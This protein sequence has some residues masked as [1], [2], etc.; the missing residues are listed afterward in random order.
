MYPDCITDLQ[1][2]RNRDRHSR[3]GQGEIHI[4]GIERQGLSELHL[5]A[6][7]YYCQG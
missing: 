2:D 4:Q 7:G 6:R 5:E 1:I 3:D